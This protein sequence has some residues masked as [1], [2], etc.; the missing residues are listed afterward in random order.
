MDRLVG[1][2]GGE[3]EGYNNGNG[4]FIF[5]VECKTNANHESEKEFQTYLD[6]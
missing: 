6:G 4:S 2:W 3:A 1:G 5:F